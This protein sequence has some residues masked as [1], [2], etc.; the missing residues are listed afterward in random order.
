[1]SVSGSRR[2]RATA[3]TGPAHGAMRV[4]WREHVANRGATTFS[5]MLAIDTTIANL[6]L[7]HIQSSLSASQHQIS[8]VLN[9]YIVAAAIMTPLTGWLA[10]RFGIKY[11]FVLSVA[12]VTAA[13]ALCGSATKLT[14]LVVYRGLQ[15]L[16]SA[17]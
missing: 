10:G 8:W 14:E 1:L 3:K 4:S 2:R 6:A 13:S 12:G 16:C 9:S 5:I 17:A 15:G 7:P 11:V